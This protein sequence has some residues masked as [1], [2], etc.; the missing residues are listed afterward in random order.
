MSNAERQRRWRENNPEAA[1]QAAKDSRSRKAGKAERPV[2]VVVELTVGEAALLKEYAADDGPYPEHAT[3]EDAARSL[4]LGHVLWWKD[5]PKELQTGGDDEA[6][7]AADKPL[8]DVLL[9]SCEARCDCPAPDSM[10]DAQRAET[11]CLWRECEAQG[12]A[13]RNVAGHDLSKEIKRTHP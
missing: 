3:L 4:V 5:V 10:T 2:K 9:D 12:K 6:Y 8:W 7:G 11:P 13:A 1:N